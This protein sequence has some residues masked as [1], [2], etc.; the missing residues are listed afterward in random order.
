MPKKTSSNET[1]G[2]RSLRLTNID[3]MYWPDDGLT[4]GDAIDYYRAIANT[5]LPY[6]KNRPVTFR[7]FPNGV[8][9]PG[10]WRRDRPNRSPEWLHG[11]AYQPETRREPITVPVVDDE[12][13]LIWFVDHAAIEIHQWLSRAD[14]LERPD[15]VVFDLD[16]GE[17][18]SFERVREAALLVRE[19]LTRSNLVAFPKTSGASGMHVFVP[20]EP[21]HPYDVVREWV[22][23]VARRLESS[24]PQQIATASGGT[25][26]GDVVTI[27]HAQNSIARNTAAPYTLRARAGAPV[28]TPLTWDEVES[29]DISPDLF[30]IRTVPERL[31]RNGDPWSAAV[32]THQRLP[33]DS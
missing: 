17:D 2:G 20:L 8:D 25:H 10:F 1:I 3:K 21:E 12:A 15:W 29:G 31:R 24:H 6:L 13:G 9:G 32:T 7:A 5:L 27:D 33:V 28:S 14:D 16:P 23:E 30:T 22:H 19:E 26:R 4:K 11:I 18:V